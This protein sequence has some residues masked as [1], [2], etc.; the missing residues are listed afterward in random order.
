MMSCGKGGLRF[1][2]PPYGELGRIELVFRAAELAGDGDAAVLGRVGDLLRGEAAEHL[3]DPLARA[4]ALVA[5]RGGAEDAHAAF[6][7]EPVE[8]ALDRHCRI[9]ELVVLDRADQRLRLAPSVVLLE[10]RHLPSR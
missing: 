7:E 6:V 9:D 3:A 1:A 10:S 5:D 4:R 8:E 2:N